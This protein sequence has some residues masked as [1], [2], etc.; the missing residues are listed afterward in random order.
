MSLETVAQKFEIERD[1]TIL[2]VDTEGRCTG[3]KDI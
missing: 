1:E 3:P 2:V